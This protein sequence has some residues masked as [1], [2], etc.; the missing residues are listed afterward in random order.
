M[1]IVVR[2][3]EPGELDRYVA[4]V[5]AGFHDE[6]RDAERIERVRRLAVPDRS[7]AAF[8]GERIVGTAGSLPFR[9]TVPGRRE[10]AAGGVTAVT[11][12]PTHRRRGI[13]RQ[14]MR[15][16]LDDARAA[17]EPLAVLWASEGGIYPRFG[18]GLASL[19]ARIDAQRDRMVLRAE[20]RAWEARL[21]SHE[22]ALEALPP[23]YDAVRLD[24]P[25][26]FARSRDWWDVHAL[27]DTPKA[28]RGAGP[29]FR[30]LL[31]LDGEPAGY[32]LYRFQHHWVDGVPEGELHVAEALGVS[33]SAHREVWRFLFGVDLTARVRARHLA[34]DDPL[35]LLVTEPTRLR[36]SVG[37]GLYLRLV[38]VA[39]AL[40]GR[41]YAGEGALTLDVADEQCYW[42]AGAW[43][44]EV[45]AGTAS[46][47]EASGG[48]DL[49]LAVGDLASAYLGGFTFSQ[50]ARAGRVEELV[51]GALARAD[52]LFRAERAPWCPENF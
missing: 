5:A 44:L 47:S 16:Q 50:L 20:P 46:V 38:D 40:A 32:A 1:Q 35:P 15:R 36:L 24:N 23:L 28:R 52:A 30:V 33:P 26:F 14:L 12:H 3:I 42:N 9:L 45:T 51:A 17:G 41:G 25:G 6:L 31:E 10:V 7:L 4:A 29:L 49:R 18:Y 34:L 8:D 11:V 13:L 19:N 22:E 43:R 21:L 39:A 37:D 2:A 27:D 48:A